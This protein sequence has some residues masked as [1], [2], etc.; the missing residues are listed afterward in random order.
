MKT[1]VMKFGGTSV[2]GATAFQN[3]ARIVA[4]RQAL[5]PVVVVSAMA[6]FTDGLLGSVR[7][8]LSA[9]AGAGSA[10]LEKHFERHFR[11][12]DVLL[13]SEAPRM[14]ELVERSR[15]E[16]DEILKRAVT[17]VEANPQ[18]RKFFEDSVAAFGERLS[19]AM[20]AAVLI[21]NSVSARDVDARRCIVTDDNYGCATPLMSSTFENSRRE[22]TELVESRCVPVL[23]G[24]IGSTESGETTTLGRGGSDYTA[25]LIGAA[26]SSDE[27]QIWTD[28]PGVLTADPRIAPKARTVPQL[29]F[30]EAAEL[31][32]FG[33]KVLHPKTLQPAIERN[34][35]VRICN[36][37]AQESG[38][39]LVVATT[40]KSEQTVKAIAHKTGVTTV[41]VT[42]TRMLGA[43]GF[44]RALFE[45]FDRHR[46]AVDVVTTSEVSVSLSLDDTTALPAIVDELERLGTVNVEEERAIVCIVGEGLRSTP[47]IAARIFSTIRD[48]NVSLISQGASR[49]NLTFAVEQARVRETVTRLHRE[50]FEEQG[51]EVEI[52]DLWTRE[53]GVNHPS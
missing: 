20:L 25:A 31:A 46:T 18:G 26:L 22:L 23:G 48:I 39:T 30:E 6:G 38:S 14:R 9:D 24:F 7:E 27:I 8:A 44:L 42:S 3:A 34:I 49:I 29:S 37:R 51:V 17:E 43:Y 45:I 16:I 53:A 35:P 5:R 47:G 50:F 21:Q 2:E 1:T 41:Q 15:G 13:T 33:A 10:A 28:V 11:V 32:Y 19:A 12:I 4:D 40:A 52:E 36:S